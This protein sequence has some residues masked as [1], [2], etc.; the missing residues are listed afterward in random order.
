MPAK[1]KEKA[2]GRERERQRGRQGDARDDARLRALRTLMERKEAA[3]RPGSAAALE[4]RLQYAKLAGGGGARRPRRR[5]RGCVPAPAA[6]PA[7]ELGARRALA[8][9]LLRLGAH[10]EAAT[11]F[12]A[13]ASDG[14]LPMVLG[15][16]LLQVATA[17]GAEGVQD[18]AYALAFATN[19]HACVLLAAPRHRRGGG[20]GRARRGRGAAAAAPGGV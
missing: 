3:A 5:R 10:E 4:T 15:R 11:L 2:F 9:L 13:W 8:P 20:R 16:L 19:W 12:D 14:A 7:D 1:D 18:E 17:S 6:A